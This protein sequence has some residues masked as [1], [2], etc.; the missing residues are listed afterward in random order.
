MG[1]LLNTMPASSDELLEAPAGTYRAPVVPPAHTV[2]TRVIDWFDEAA[3][4]L[5]WRRPECSAWGVMVSEVMLQQTPVSRVLPRWEEWMRRW[6]TPQLTAQAPTAEILRV[7]DRLGYPRRAMRLQAAAQAITERHGG[8]VPGQTD[9]LRALPG[10]GEY[11][12]AAVA[13]FAFGEP[14]IVVDTNIRRVHARVFAGEALPGQTY[15][16]A[17]RRRAA[18]LMPPTA[19]D[20]GRRAC[21]WNAAAMELGALI[22]TAR[23]PQ[24]AICPVADLCA[25]KLAGS[26]PAT[27]QQRTRGQSW[28]GTDR[29]VRGTIMAVLREHSSLAESALLE[30]SA[31]QDFSREQCQRCID[32][33]TRDGLTE[34]ADGRIGLPGSSVGLQD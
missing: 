13:C 9:A 34:T 10:V 8:E 32:S 30:S 21:A 14:E 7:W 22:C 33:L 31:L 6:P 24:C 19:D 27:A 20:G 1:T 25:W 2:H 18:E 5:P 15:T 28:A 3:R 4:D 26:P 17:Q 23:S 12:A 11:T 16:A 29:Q